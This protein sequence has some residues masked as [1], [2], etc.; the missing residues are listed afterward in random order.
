[1]SEGDYSNFDGVESNKNDKDIK[2]NN[3][4][5]V[6]DNIINISEDIIQNKYEPVMNNINNSICTINKFSIL[7]N[8]LDEQKK[9]M[10]KDYYKSCCG[11]SCCYSCGLKSDCQNKDL[12]KK[13]IEEIQDKEKEYINIL[14][15]IRDEYN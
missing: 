14:E 15:E 11:C 13:K 10:E 1:M 7:L 12:V 4:N 5:N 3:N 9:Q 8:E 2:D 6:L